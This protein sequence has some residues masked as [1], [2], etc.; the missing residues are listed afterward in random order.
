MTTITHPARAVILALTGR[1]GAGKDTTAAHLAA[2]Y[3]F[4][5]ASFAEPIKSMLAALLAEAGIDEAWAYDRTLRERPMPGLNISYRRLMQ[6]LGT[7]WGRTLDDDLW[8]RVLARGIGWPGGLVHDRIVITDVRFPNEALWVRHAVGAPLWRI[9]RHTAAARACAG[10]AS[11][12]HVDTLPATHEL[13][14]TGTAGQLFTRIDALCHELGI[15][16]RDDD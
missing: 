9:R 10:H 12:S 14:N 16:P 11:E 2:H 7:D 6:T 15:A 13:D 4:A 3:G 5:Q 1:A 8:I